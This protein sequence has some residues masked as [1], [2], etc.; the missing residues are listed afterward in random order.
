LASF[1]SSRRDKQLKGIS[2]KKEPN[3]KTYMQRA[4]ALIIG[5]FAM[6]LIAGAADTPPLPSGKDVKWG[7]P[8]AVFPTGAKFAVMAGDPGATGLITVR[9]EMP[10]GY[11]IPPHFHP[12]DEHIRCSKVNFQSGWVM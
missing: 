1:H 10:A 6:Q 5:L 9:F 11:L 3:M 2:S 7:A 8:P 12:T 4:G